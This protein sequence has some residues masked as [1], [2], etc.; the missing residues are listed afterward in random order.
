MT[1]AYA[2]SNPAV[3]AN[4]GIVRDSENTRAPYKPVGR[5]PVKS[6]VG[7]SGPK[8]EI[9]RAALGSNVKQFIRERAEISDLC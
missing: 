1:P 6:D 8:V 4:P 7:P 3:P 5:S 2:G 9:I